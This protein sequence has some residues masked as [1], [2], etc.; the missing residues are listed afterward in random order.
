MQAKDDAERSGR[1]SGDSDDEEAAAEEV[2]DAVDAVVGEL[3]D[4]KVLRG[5]VT[6]NRDLF[7]TLMKVRAITAGLA[8]QVRFGRNEAEEGDKLCRRCGHETGKPETNWHVLWECPYSNI[9][10]KRRELQ[11]E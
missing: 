7:C 8:T 6:R 5:F 2:E 1:C 4:V 10:Q 9:V 3:V 11:S